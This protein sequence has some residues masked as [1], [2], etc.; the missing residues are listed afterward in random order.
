[1]QDLRALAE[2]SRPLLVEV[3]R[4]LKDLDAGRL[5]PTPLHD[6]AKTG[7]LR[8]CGKIVVASEASPSTG[9]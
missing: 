2:R 7:D 9:S 3:F 1:M 6:Y 8:A 5:V 4:L